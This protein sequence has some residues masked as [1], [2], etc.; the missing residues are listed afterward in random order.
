MYWSRSLDELHPRAAKKARQLI[1]ECAVEDIE[2]IVTCTYRDEEAERALHAF[3]RTAP[4]REISH[5]RPPQSLMPFRVAFNVCLLVYGVPVPF[6]RTPYERR[7]WLRVSEI[8]KA[9]GLDWG[10]KS[11]ARVEWGRFAFTKGLTVEQ[12]R[13]GKTL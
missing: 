9:L 3:G 12:F 8:G 7:L 10:I 2:L 11:K 6:P 13:A 1:A 5:E 4:G